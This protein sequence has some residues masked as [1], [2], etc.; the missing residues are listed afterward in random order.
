MLTGGI[1]LGG[2]ILSAGRMV[3]S[4][5]VYSGLVVCLTV[6]FVLLKLSELARRRLLHWHAESGPAS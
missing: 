6:G 1:G 3:D 4:V 2:S 5:G